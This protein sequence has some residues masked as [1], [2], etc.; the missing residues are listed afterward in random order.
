MYQFQRN[1][2]FGKKRHKK[3]HNKLQFRVIFKRVNRLI[4]FQLR[5]LFLSFVNGI[6]LMVFLII[7]VCLTL[8]KPE[9][10]THVVYENVLGM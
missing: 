7:A 3:L 4:L 5:P 6:T 1:N 9:R 10:I 8:N 2:D